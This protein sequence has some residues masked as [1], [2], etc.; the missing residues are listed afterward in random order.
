[1]APAFKKH[2]IK[3]Q[4]EKRR[5]FGEIEE[6]IQSGFLEKMKPEFVLKAEKKGSHEEGG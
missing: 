6:V 2:S 4:S 5:L 1:M 3:L